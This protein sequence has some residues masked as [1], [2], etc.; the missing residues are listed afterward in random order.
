[1]AAATEAANAAARIARRR[2]DEAT[3]AGCEAGRRRR[4]ELLEAATPAPRDHPGSR[5][6]RSRIPA[7]PAE[8]DDSSLSSMSTP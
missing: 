5:S 8:A 7:G 2:R 6:P 4:S 1:M 3:E